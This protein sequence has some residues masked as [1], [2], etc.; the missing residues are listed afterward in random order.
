VRRWSLAILT[1]LGAALV[2]AATGSPAP[3]SAKEGTTI[4]VDYP[5]SDTDFWNSF[6]S[7]TPKFAK[8]LHVTLKTTN[9][10]NDIAKL[11]ANV[12]TLISEGVKGVVIAPQDTAAVIP[13]LKLLATTRR[14]GRRPASSWARSCTGR[15]RS[16]CSRAMSPRSTDETAQPRSQPA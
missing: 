9:S 5:R 13:T 11:A 8:S 15:A 10:A 12:Q 2:L 4:G 7:Y 6:I 3:S 14:T 1:V 16:S